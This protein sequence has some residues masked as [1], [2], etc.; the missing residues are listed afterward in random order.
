MSAIFFSTCYNIG[1]VLKLFS[2]SRSIG[3]VCKKVRR[4]ERKKEERKK[5]RKKEGR[6]EEKKEGRKRN[7]FLGLYPYIK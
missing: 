3:V 1:L 4:K 2:T 7:S 5:E 6:K